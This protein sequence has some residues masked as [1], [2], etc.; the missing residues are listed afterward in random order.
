MSQNKFDWQLINDSI[1]SDDK[2]KLTDFINTD[3][4][5]FTQGK[6]VKE[7][8]RKWS[9]WLG[10]KHTVFVNS[11]ASANYIMTS[12]MKEKKGLG[13]VIVS[14]IGWVS[15][16][17]PLV[18]LGFTPVFVDVDFNNMSITFDNIKNAL[19]D[20]TVG[21]NLVHCLGFN[22]INE[23]IVNFAKDNDLF[24]I[25]DCCESHGV[26]YK[27]K[28]IGTFGDVSNFSFYF[29]HHITSVEGGV[30]CTNDDELY[31]YAKLFRSHGMT[32]EASPK[33]QEMYE[34]HYPDLNPLFTFAVP[35]YNLRNQEFN[36]VLGLSQLD[37]LD[38]NVNRRK[39]NLDTWLDNL[40]SKQFFTDF[41]REGNS[42][43]SLPLILLKK[44]LDIFKKVRILLDEEN[45]EFR[46]G[47][48]GGGNQARQP[49]LE[50]Y[51][52]RIDNNLD[53]TNHIHDFGLYIGNHPELNNEQIINLCG[54]L[55][56]L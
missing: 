50:K 17:A 22:A 23:D 47:T 45:V 33:L 8:E 48:A 42:N 34:L 2:K 41:N 26:T 55:N 38:Y 3:G 54:K 16:V 52:F 12:M 6:Y 43:F 37:R 56:D 28:K 30:V 51:N 29:G 9:E 39:E 40:D 14:P 24:L 53:N 11:G 36:A 21:I 44:D 1:T 35:G 5:R 10:I 49:Y 25:E 20:K 19:T 46:V 15:D 18:N 7:F 31:D 13:E 27:D 32:R 4:V